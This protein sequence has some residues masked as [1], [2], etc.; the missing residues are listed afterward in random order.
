MLDNVVIYVYILF[1]IAIPNI[2]LIISLFFL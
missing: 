2:L 1:Y